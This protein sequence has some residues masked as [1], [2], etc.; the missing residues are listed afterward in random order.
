MTEKTMGEIYLEP[1]EEIIKNAKE[2]AVESQTAEKYIFCISYEATEKSVVLSEIKR[3]ECEI[4]EQSDTKT[5]VTVK[6][7][8]A[9]LAAIKSL[10]CIEKVEMA[11][12]YFATTTENV[13]ET[14]N[15]NV[16][17]EAAFTEHVSLVTMEEEAISIMCYGGDSGSDCDNSNT[18]QTAYYLPISSWVNGCICCPGTEIWYRF[19]ASASNAAEY[20]IYTSGSLDTMGYLYSSNGTLIT[21]NDDG[22]ENLNFSITDELTYGATYYVKV[23]AYGSNTGD[24]DIRVGYT[25]QSSSGDQNDSDCSNDQASAIQLTLNSWRSDEICCPGAEM[26]YKFTPSST[27]Y[28]T[29]YTVGSLDTVGHIYDATCNQIDS[30][31]DAGTGLNFRMVARLTAGQTYYIKAKA[32]GN[33]TGIFSIVVTNTVFVESVTINNE[34]VTLNEGDS[35]TLTANV[36]PSYATNKSLRWQSSDNNVAIVNS[37]TGKVTAINRGSACVCAYSQDG[38]NKSSCCE[39]IVNVFAKSVSVTPA[40][41]SMYVGETAHLT[42]T[43]YP[44][45][46]QNKSVTW[47]SSNPEIISVDYYSGII[48]ANSAGTAIITATTVYGGFSDACVV[49]ANEH[50]DSNDISTA[51]YLPLSK[52]MNGCI[53]CPD[54]EIWYR[55]TAN[56]INADEYTVFTRGSL[57]TMGY[58]YDSNGTLIASNDDGGENLNFI[59]TDELTYGA[60]YY[61]KVKAYGSN[62]GDYDIRVGY[63]TQ[64]SSG[65]QNDSDCSN[66]QA[67]AI[68]LSLNS[69]QSGE[70][71]CPGAEMWYKFTPSTTAYYT[72]YTVGSLDTYGYLYD[73]NGTE[74]DHDDDDGSSLNFKMV[75]RLAANQTYYIKAKAFGN[76]TGYFSIAVTSTVFVE[77][78]SINKSYIALDKG[79]TEDLDATVTPSNATNPTLRWETGDASVAT[80]S[81]SGVVTARGAGTTCICAYS[82][83]GSNKSS[84]CEVAVN[85]PVESV[86]IN[87]SSLLMRMG[88]DDDLD[89]EVCPTDAVNKLIRWTSSNTGVVW[90]NEATGRVE[91]R[92]VGS[93]TIYATAQDGTGVKGSCAIQVEPPIPVQG[94]D[95]CC[96]N[97]TMNV[98]ETTKL[99]YD[100][101][102]SDATNKGVTWS[103][104]DSRIASVDS[105][106]KVYAKSSGTTTVTAT[107]LDGN[108]TTTCMLTITIDTVTIKKDGVFNKVVFNSSGKVWRCINYDLIFDENHMNDNSLLT[109]SRRNIYLDEVGNTKDFKTY[110]DNEIKLL[111]AIDPYGVAHYVQQYATGLPGGLETTLQYKDRIFRLLFNREPKYF[112]RYSDGITWYETTDKSNVNAVQSESECVFGMHPIWDDYTIEQI[113]ETVITMVDLA[114]SVTLSIPSVKAYLNAHKTIKTISK[115]FAFSVSVVESDFMS[116]TADAFIEKAFDNTSVEWAY[117]MVSLYSSLHELISNFDTGEN[118]YKQILDYCINDLGYNIVVELK[119]GQRYGFKEIRE[120]MV[121]D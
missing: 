2:I 112:A 55:F 32:F 62:T 91:A 94:I 110:S 111:Y 83:D 77:T 46:A 27:A 58:L 52:W 34:S 11:D 21:S 15:T 54:A 41:K 99:S 93:A 28:Y 5:C 61:V 121:S 118:Y 85:V 88:E 84:C 22:G 43:V 81:Q 92:G 74:I 89:A 107:T 102:P 101:Y 71:C 103:S 66:D 24:Y 120:L 114:I 78:V 72:I 49:T 38:S 117:E 96:D 14:M 26:W 13:S 35:I 33:N 97:Y 57:D 64:S 59:I 19:T 80:V 7:S 29:V 105:T 98:G 108:F 37:S 60:T 56:A 44:T 10:N 90:V 9:Q 76:N 36:L 113:K 68:Q 70:I 104:S 25:T 69:W 79:K 8:M 86:T 6:A 20:T 12:E 65:D 31:D 67:S 3:L 119:S 47:C 45:N 30:D 1:E 100:I 23:K 48:T 82:Q 75:Q 109:R 63:T 17:T 51:F 95:I 18:M 87:T 106:G 50:G 116:A 4:L 115:L 53:C 40:T 42:A 16:M 73:A 39:V